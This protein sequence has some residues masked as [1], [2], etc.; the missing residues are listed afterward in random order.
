M[1]S[2]SELE[3]LASKNIKIKMNYINFLGVQKLNLLN[4]LLS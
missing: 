2:V 4:F 1:T 3:V